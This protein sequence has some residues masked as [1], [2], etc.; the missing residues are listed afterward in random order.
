MPATGRLQVPQPAPFLQHVGDLPLPIPTWF[1]AFDAYLD[2]LEEERGQALTAALKNSLLF[3][4]LGPEGQRHFGSH[5]LVPKIKDATTTYAL[6][7]K[8]ILDPGPFQTSH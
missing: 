1:T 2:L 3:S 8:A 7:K 5:P 4:L 6:F